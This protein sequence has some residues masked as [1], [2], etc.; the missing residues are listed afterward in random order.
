MWLLLAGKI[1]DQ[2]PMGCPP[3]IELNMNMNLFDTRSTL[4]CRYAKKKKKNFIIQGG[5]VSPTDDII[6]HSTEVQINF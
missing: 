6:R 1:Q 4:N 5:G 3:G 2:T